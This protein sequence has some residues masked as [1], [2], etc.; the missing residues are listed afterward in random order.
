MDIKFLKKQNNLTVSNNKLIY[1][2]PISEHQFVTY[3]LKNL[4]EC[5]TVTAEEYVLLRS[6]YYKFSKDLK[7]LVINQ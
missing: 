6:R 5:I 1:I 4:A 3:P 7:T 2:K